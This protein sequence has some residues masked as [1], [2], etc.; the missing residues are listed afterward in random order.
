MRLKLKKK[1]WI[2]KKIKKLNKSMLIDKIE[3]K[4]SQEKDVNPFQTY[5]LSY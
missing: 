1:T 5:D 3:K 2:E 4:I